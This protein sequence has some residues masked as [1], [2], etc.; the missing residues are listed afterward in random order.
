MTVETKILITGDD[1]PLRRALGSARDGLNRFGTEA[2]EPFGKIR[3]AL[4]NLGNIMAGV[5]AIK[6]IG[7][8]DQ[9]ALI[10]ARLKDV[11]GS[12]QAGQQAQGQLFAASQRLQ[13]SYSDMA[14]SFS[15]M[16]PAVKEMGGGAREAVRLAETLAISARLSGASSAEASA[17]AQQFAQALQSGV[18]QG[19]E[20][21]SILENNGALSRMLATGLG[22]SVDQLK[23]LGEQGKLTS[24]KVAKALLGQYDEIQARSAELPATVG[25]AWQQVTNSFE[26]FVA[27]SEVGGGVFAGVS[28][29]L[30]GMSRFIDAVRSALGG[31]SAESDKLARN[32]SIKAW[33]EAV[34]AT[35]AVVVDLARAVWE[36]IQATGR[37]IGGL[38]AAAASAASGQFADAANIMRMAADDASASWERIKNLGT[39]GKGSTLFA[40]ATNAG[41]AAADTSPTAELSGK[42]GGN[43]NKTKGGGAGGD[44]S[45]MGAME[46]ALQTQKAYLAEQGLLLNQSKQFELKYW[47]DILEASARAEREKLQGF[48]LSEAD[49]ISILKKSADLRM[50]IAQEEAK[51]Q[52]DLAAEGLDAWKKIEML[53]VDAQ[54]VA[55]KA[56]LEQDKITKVQALDREIEFEEKRLQITLEYL[57]RR[58]ELLPD[59]DAVGRSKISNQMTAEGQQSRNK[60]SGLQGQRDK[61]AADGPIDL[62]GMFEK[63]GD[64]AAS[65]FGKILAGAQN[66]RSQM[67]N[68][69]NSIRDQFIRSVVT[70]PL[71]AQLAAWGRMLVAKLG[72]MV[73]EK[74]MDAAGATTTVAVKGQETT[75]VAEMNA[76]QAATGA[77][78]SQ[79]PIPVVGPYLAI[80]A[81]AAIFAAVSAMGSK[82]KSARNGYD[83]PAGVNPMTQLHEEEMVLPKE[84]ANAIRD[85]ASGGGG[86]GGGGSVVYN[87]HSGRLS[88]SDIRR[89][90]GV[91]ATELNRLHRNGWRAN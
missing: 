18:L 61:A 50:A 60:K 55:T 12:I 83:I 17:S 45:F 75:A 85:M 70:E 79:A 11:T 73:Q 30:S 47:Q 10:Q 63:M 20:L 21:K 69:Y 62:A 53:R 72:F 54:D 51:E 65:G 4:G 16:L 66:L 39:G 78:G 46:S 80:A 49:K 40:Y 5:G 29:V 35:F 67:V 56:M 48:R 81:M 33:G 38:A 74:A 14:G 68:I 90:A 89:K 91:I 59:D 42:P 52:L 32:N 15:K 82:V 2:L 34:G 44:K 13:V 88:D 7:L 37:A 26:Q 22:I 36:A 24:D 8:A 19:D 77:A 23:D 57:R 84:Q 1:A 86:G 58:Q 28:A 25:G 71:Q 9:A 31:A 41:I 43:K 27:S 87:D 6:L 3:D 64:S 76:I